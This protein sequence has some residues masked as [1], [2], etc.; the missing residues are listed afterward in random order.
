MNHFFRFFTILLVIT[1][2]ISA[3]ESYGQDQNGV[4]LSLIKQDP[5]QGSSVEI[6]S[7]ENIAL[8]GNTTELAVDKMTFQYYNKTRQEWEALTST[9]SNF[10]FNNVGMFTSKEALPDKTESQ[11][12]RLKYVIN[13][14]EYFTVAFTISV[15]PGSSAGGISPRNYS[16]LHSAALWNSMKRQVSGF[17]A[18]MRAV[19][20]C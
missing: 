3:K 18:T 7:G 1:F 15:R 11:Q 20:I 6:C 14:I 17:L 10:E 4:Y 2:S 12:Y 16:L 5:S 19:Y 13:Q 9:F 8:Y